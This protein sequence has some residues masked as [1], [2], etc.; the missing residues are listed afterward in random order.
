MHAEESA[1][2]FV[3]QC[4]VGAGM[5]PGYVLHAGFLVYV[6]QQHVGCR[7]GGKHDVLSMATRD[8]IQTGG[9]HTVH[10]AAVV[11]L[12]MQHVC[13]Q[14]TGLVTCLEVFALIR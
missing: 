6:H 4:V 12:C 3:V 13:P 8:D 9:K 14:L 2:V 10:L 11:V 1:V 5:L 7:A